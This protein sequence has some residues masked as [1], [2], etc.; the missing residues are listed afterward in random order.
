M[1]SVWSFFK[2][3]ATK[4]EPNRKIVIFHVNLYLRQTIFCHRFLQPEANRGFLGEKITSRVSNKTPNATAG[5]CEFLYCEK[6][7]DTLPKKYRTPD[8]GSG[9]IH[10]F[11]AQQVYEKILFFSQFN[12][13]SDQRELDNDGIHLIKR[14]TH[15][16][17]LVFSVDKENQVL[18]VCNSFLMK[19]D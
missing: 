5:Y 15:F 17:C 4:L 9:F 16:V 8:F 19:I 6:T 14:N 10:S 18:F 7:S 3:V 11:Y 13:N 1:F 12:F 2:L